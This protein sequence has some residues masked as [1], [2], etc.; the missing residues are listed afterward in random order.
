MHFYIG[1]VDELD[2]VSAD[3]RDFDA[4]LFKSRKRKNLRNFKEILRLT[5]RVG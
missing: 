5:E 4:L 1:L 2:V 3:F